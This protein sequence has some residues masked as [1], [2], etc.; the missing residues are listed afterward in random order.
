M[1][2]INDEPDIKEFDDGDN[3]DDE[4]ISNE[5]DVETTQLNDDDDDDDDVYKEE[6]DDDDDD[7][8]MNEIMKK[9][10]KAKKLKERS[11]EDDDDD[12][13]DDVDDDDDNDDDDDDMQQNTMTTPKNIHPIMENLNSQEVSNFDDDDEYF[14]DDF[15]F[16]KFDDELRSSYIQKYHPEIIQKNLEQIMALTK[17]TRNVNN[18]IEDDLHRTIPF[19]TKYE[20]TRILGLRIKQLNE[21]ARPYINV[22]EVFNTSKFLDNF[23]IAE[24]ELEMKKLPFIIARPITKSHTEYWCLRDLELIH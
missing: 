18:I 11:D 7:D 1:E 6:D 21:G 12:D 3:S 19:L 17:I 2:Q 22:K 20:K 9:K 23:T 15:S 4:S 8:T 5:D 10:Q 13:D 16:E 14:E 24:H